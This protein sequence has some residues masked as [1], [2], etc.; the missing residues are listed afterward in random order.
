MSFISIDVHCWFCS[1]R[2]I[3]QSLDHSHVYERKALF[4]VNDLVIDVHI[5]GSRLHPGVYC[6]A[7]EEKPHLPR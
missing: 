6:K 1:K 7:R 4:Q 5:A 3:G 2:S